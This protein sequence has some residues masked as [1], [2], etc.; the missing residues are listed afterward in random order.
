VKV[1]V[2]I[3]VPAEAVPA[4]RMSGSALIR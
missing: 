1:L 4:S 3:P 2:E